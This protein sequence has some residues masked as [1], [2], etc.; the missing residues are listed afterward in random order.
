MERQK[1]DLPRNAFGHPLPRWG[2]EEGSTAEPM[3]LHSS[4]QG[5]LPS[6]SDDPSESVGLQP[7][8]WGSGDDGSGGGGRT[9]PRHH[10]LHPALPCRALCVPLGA[11]KSPSGV[12]A[13]AGSL[14]RGHKPGVPPG[15]RHSCCH[16]EALHPSLGATGPGTL[17]LLRPEPSSEDARSAFTV[18]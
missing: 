11:L 8:C 3:V 9:S 17:H 6:A 18:F 2:N 10:R 15:R 1:G 12:P 14:A 13:G 4:I 16:S 5:P 7:R